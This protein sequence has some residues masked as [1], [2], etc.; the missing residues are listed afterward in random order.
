MTAKPD[1]EKNFFFWRLQALSGIE[2]KVGCDLQFSCEGRTMKYQIKT[3]LGRIRDDIKQNIVALLMI[4]VYAVVVQALFHKVCPWLILT[5]IPCPGCG[6]T[7]AGLLL[8]S[9]HFIKAWQMNPAI[10]LWAP[11]LVYLCF[12]RYI[13]AKKPP[14]TLPFTIFVGLLTL[15]IYCWNFS[16]LI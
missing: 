7:R 9:G 10:Y 13:L 4:A 16:Y 8:L 1:R 12:Y 5:G 15:V 3:I 2:K 14:F 6:L 11:F